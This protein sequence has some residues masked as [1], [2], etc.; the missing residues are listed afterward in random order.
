MPD[1]ET[2][3]TDAELLAAARAGDVRGFAGIYDRYSERIFSFCLTIL[4][5]TS[6]AAV[7][8]RD[9][10]LDVFSR[11]AEVEPSGLGVLLFASAHD[12]I[13]SQERHRS[14]LSSGAASAEALS[15][16]LAVDSAR[17]ALIVEV[18]EAVEALGQRDQE[19]MTLHLVEGLQSEELAEVT[20]VDLAYV[21]DLVS[22]MEGRVQAA[23]GPLLIA[24]LGSEDCAD[25]ERLL[26]DWDGEF[27]TEVRALVARHIGACP[28]CQE[29]RAFLT[30]PGNVL[31]VI[32]VVP[33]PPSLR[34]HVMTAVDEMLRRPEE[35][36]ADSTPV[37]VSAAPAPPERTISPFSR[38]P[39]ERDA[40]LEE[41]T[42]LVLFA[43][44]TL[45]VGLIGLA[46]SAK[47]EPPEPPA[48]VPAGVSFETSTSTSPSSSTTARGN[49][50]VATPVQSTASE[51]G[52]IETS[53]DTIGFGEEG[54]NAEFEIRNTGG[55]PVEF[56][57]VSSSKSVVLSS[58]GQMLEPGESVTY[59]VLLDREEVAEGEISESITVEWEGR[60]SEITVTATQM[61]NPILHNPQATPGTVQVDGCPESTT[62]ISVRIRD[63][64]PLADVVVRWS[65]DGGGVEET[66]MKAMGGDIFEARIGPF[67]KP[68]T[69]SVRIVATDELGNAGGA[70][71]P[72][73]VVV[74]S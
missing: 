63:R 29:E 23:L 27:T 40:G 19:L 2:P 72:I 11:V 30:A 56:S 64:S 15:A 17:A 42:K 61:D 22:R 58:G 59:Q 25:L 41:K 28:T 16:E 1:L 36:A 6:E 26:T 49:Q 43:G 67:E 8:T 73:E 35:E 53:T 7:A 74:C 24:R 70:A 48:T 34:Q 57:V 46:V 3:P 54:T 14:P 52:A 5:S 33:A 65:P 12:E 39:P 32:M 21:D 69:A 71:I 60:T 4:R 9:A 37:V 62:T 50:D 66:E 10:F 18:W 13:R 44:V 68:Q 51:P 20:T 55:R 45:V 47:F 38:P 31:P